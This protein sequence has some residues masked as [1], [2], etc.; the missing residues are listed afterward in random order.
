[1]C[2]CS[3]Q[4]LPNLNGEQ[5]QK[6]WNLV[7]WAMKEAGGRFPVELPSVHSGYVSL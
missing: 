6:K 2:S 4:R 1:M 3:A 7:N 5:R